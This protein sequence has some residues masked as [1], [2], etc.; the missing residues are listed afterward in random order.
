VFSDAAADRARENAR[1]K[2]KADAKNNEIQLRIADEKPE[3][4][5]PMR[6]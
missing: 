6:K 3:I 4:R 1:G 2:Q 5:N